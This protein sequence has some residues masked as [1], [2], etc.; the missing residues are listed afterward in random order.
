M[1]LPS[2]TTPAQVR[3]GTPSCTIPGRITPTFIHT[4]AHTH[5]HA[6]RS[7][8]QRHITIQHKSTSV[9]STSCQVSHTSTIRSAT[10][11]LGQPCSTCSGHKK[12]LILCANTKYQPALLG[13]NFGPLQLKVFLILFK[14]SLIWECFLSGLHPRSCFG[15][16]QCLLFN[17]GCIFNPCLMGIIT[18]FRGK[19]KDKM[20]NSILSA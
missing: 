11:S 15:R 17:D 8:A 10:P 20:G 6:H 2:C 7:H 4:L 5:T 19:M 3:G 9:L 14:G 18:Y 13:K 16:L 12:T 1:G